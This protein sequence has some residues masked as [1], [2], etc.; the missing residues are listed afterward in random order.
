MLGILAALAFLERPMSATHRATVLATGLYKF[1]S[2]LAASNIKV[3]DLA[4]RTHIV[5]GPKPT[6]GYSP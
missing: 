4:G 3:F 5:P 6:A 2:M 1:A